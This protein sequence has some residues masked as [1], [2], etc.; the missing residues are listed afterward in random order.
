MFAS[1]QLRAFALLGAI[2]QCAAAGP[3]FALPGN[4]P[5]VAPGPAF[6]QPIARKGTR[7][8]VPDAIPDSQADTAATD[9]AAEKKA[10]ADCIEIWDA[11]THITKSKWREICKRQIKER[12]ALLAP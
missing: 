3:S 9:P 7:N 10:L 4:K 6:L 5:A 1:P 2:V 8:Y 11:K 12:G